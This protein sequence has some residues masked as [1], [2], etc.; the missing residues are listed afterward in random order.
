MGTAAAHGA[1][2]GRRRLDEALAR[3]ALPQ[4]M[5][6]TPVG[7]DDVLNAFWQAMFQQVERGV[8]PPRAPRIATDENGIIIRDEHGNA[9]GGV[10]LP[11]FEVPKAGYFSPLNT[12]KPICT[13][14][15]TPEEDGCLPLPP[16]IAPLLGLACLL[17]GGQEP[18]TADELESLYPHRG[19]FTRQYSNQALKLAKQRM[20][21]RD[22]ARERLIGILRDDYR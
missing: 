22:D 13:D 9:L 1:V 2:A 11:E 17:A 19:I 8:L 10:R 6:Q 4:L 15:R 21:L 18:F 7:G 14:G 5:E 3:V 16:A 20:L 12:L